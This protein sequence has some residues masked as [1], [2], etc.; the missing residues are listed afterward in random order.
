M[1]RAPCCDKANVKKGPWSPEEDAALR[2][3]IHNHGIGGNWIS[4]PKKAGLKRC[5]KSCRLRWL[6]YLRPNIKHG[7][8]TKEED[9]IILSLY[10]N[11]GSRWSVIASKLPGRTDNDVKN[12]WNTKLKKRMIEAQPQ[13]LRNQISQAMF[14]G[15]SVLGGSS[16]NGVIMS[17][18]APASQSLSSGDDEDSPAMKQGLR[19]EYDQNGL[20]LTDLDFGSSNTDL[21]SCPGFLWADDVCSE[22]GFIGELFFH[23]FTGNEISSNGVRSHDASP[24][25]EI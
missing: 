7:C 2:S 24:S 21:L 5:G 9:D 11:I 8:F 18:E 12:H 20:L 19:G 1:G 16:S 6:N 14:S 23:N 4:L 22:E 10:S 15:F 13:V 17:T 3:F 25:K